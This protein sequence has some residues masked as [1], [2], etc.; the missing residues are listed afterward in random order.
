MKSIIKLLIIII[1]FLSLISPV[2]ANSIS[3][4]SANLVKVRTS[5]EIVVDPR[6]AKMDQFLHRYNSPLS[7]HSQFIVET[8]DKYDLPW[9]L[10]VSISG[11]ESGFC[12]KI[13]KGSYNCWGWKN[14]SHYFKSIEDGIFTVTKT[15]R[16]KYF[17]RGITTP[18]SIAP[19]YAP[20]S[21]TWSRKV[22]FFMNLLENTRLADPSLQI[23][24]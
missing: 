8:S 15:L 13:I 5:N 20:P 23:T 19:I 4:S 22:R 17:D 6:V 2:S 24:L 3:G 14:G 18:E 7:A 16:Y 1:T 12:K 21:N 9:T 11:V 10:L